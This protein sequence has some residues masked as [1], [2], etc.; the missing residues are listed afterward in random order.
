MKRIINCLLVLLFLLSLAS[1]KSGDTAAIAKS[2]ATQREGGTTL[3]RE[4]PS[5]Q[6][7][8]LDGPPDGAQE[9]TYTSGDYQLKAWITTP[10]TD[11]KKH[12]AVVY[13]HGGFAFGLQDWLDIQ[14]YIDAGY[15]VMVPMRRGENGNPGSFEFFFGEVDDTIAAGNYFSKQPYVDT[16]RLF[17]SGH[18]TGGT[19]AMLAAMLPSPYQAVASFEGA[20]DIKSFIGINLSKY[21]P[22]KKEQREY[23]IRS[24][25]KQVSSLDKPL[26][27]Y[28][29]SDNA[30]IG[31]ENRDIAKRAQ[32][33]G[34][35]CELNV[36]KGDH[37]TMLQGC[38]VASI[39]VFDSFGQK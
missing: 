39:E 34:K 19:L 13:A 4:M 1:C 10:P 9:V 23:D 14:P 26:Y 17:L 32:A 5:P 12:P 24:A 16:E 20:P 3:V 36:I 29:P 25:I 28:L 38:M 11:G 8:D 30:A 15:Q 18:S 27:I 6:D 37:I 21:V 33:L 22:F 31:R 7:Y 2:F 35:T